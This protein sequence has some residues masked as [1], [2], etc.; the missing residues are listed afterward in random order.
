MNKLH[1]ELKNKING[2]FKNN[3]PFDPIIYYKNVT[4]LNNTLT[5]KYNSIWSIHIKS[6]QNHHIYTDAKTMLYITLDKTILSCDIN[7]DCWEDLYET[8]DKL[9]T[10]SENLNYIFIEDFIVI[11]NNTI[12][13]ITGS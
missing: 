6:F 11:N 4:L 8:A 13:L 3:I 9:I 7:G 10:L 5:G 12:R 2:I 1:I